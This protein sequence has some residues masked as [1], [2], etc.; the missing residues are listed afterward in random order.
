MRS[1]RPMHCLLAFAQILG[2]LLL[3]ALAGCGP[4]LL[5]PVEGQLLDKAGNPVTAMKGGSIEFQS[6]EQKMSSSG[7]IDENGKFRL[8]TATPNDGAP[9]YLLPMDITAARNLTTTLM[10]TLV[11][12]ADLR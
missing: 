5:Y 3:L 4:R 6:R 2:G 11:A 9:S 10:R 12:L 7:S 8:S 1:R